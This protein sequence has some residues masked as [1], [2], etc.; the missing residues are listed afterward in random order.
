MDNSR[1]WELRSR[2]RLPSYKEP[3]ESDIYSNSKAEK[4]PK[5]RQQEPD[6]YAVEVLE[7]D[8]TKCRV[9][10]VGYDSCYD[11][12]KD[13][14]EI[15][16]CYEPCDEDSKTATSDKI[17]RFSLYDELSVKIK[18]SLNSSR[19]ESPIVRID[20]PFDKI[21]FD[22][23]IRCCGHVKRSVRGIERY[24][25]TKY[26]DL[27][28]LLGV[29]WHFR[30]I[31]ENGD[32]CYII[33]NTIEFYLYRRRPIK[34]FMPG[35]PALRVTYKS[36]GYVLVFCFVKGNGTPSQFGSNQTIFVN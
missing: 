1:K 16:D 24:T 11:E 17:F 25:I 4:K 13:K 28:H 20:M 36:T 33:L 31:N 34:E 15:V 9:H 35:T 32:F 3:K 26:Q 6:L 7:E 23:G 5:K 18:S 22:G 12:W 30:G 2:T 14:D 21:E 27:N 19:K 10:Y 29:D 8:S